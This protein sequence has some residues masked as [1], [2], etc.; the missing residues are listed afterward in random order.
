MMI[1]TGQSIMSLNI[2]FHQTVVS[3]RLQ[4]TVKNSTEHNPIME[5]VST[6]IRVQNKISDN[7]MS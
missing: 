4:M 7:I 3:A 2:K 6:N 5:S 1:P